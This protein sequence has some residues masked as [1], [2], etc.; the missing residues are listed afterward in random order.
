MIEKINLALENA[1]NNYINYKN[2]EKK[3]LKL[4]DHISALHALFESFIHYGFAVSQITEVIKTLDEDTSL[5]EV[6]IEPHLRIV[7]DENMIAK[8]YTKMYVQYIAKISVGME[9]KKAVEKLFA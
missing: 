2:L 1:E 3:E 9:S 4:P 7:N 8:Q 5:F 6:L